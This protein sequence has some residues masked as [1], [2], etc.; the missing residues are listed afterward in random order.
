MPELTTYQ[1]LRMGGVGPDSGVNFNVFRWFPDSFGTPV[2]E[3]IFTDPNRARLILSI[4]VTLNKVI[5]GDNCSFR[6]IAKKVGFVPT[7]LDPGV[8]V[9]RTFITDSDQY[10]DGSPRIWSQGPEKYYITTNTL[11]WEIK[12]RL[13]LDQTMNL[14]VIQTDD[15]NNGLTVV[16]IEYLTGDHDRLI[17]LL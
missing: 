8:E 7:I 1:S 2:D 16:E 3:D 4:R 9:F 14:N 5:T 15:W 12:P 13:L 10:Q 17:E 11:R 6:V